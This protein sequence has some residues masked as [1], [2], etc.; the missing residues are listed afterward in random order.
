MSRGLFSSLSLPRQEC[1][2]PLM[3]Q[4][5]PRPSDIDLL[6]RDFLTA[7]DCHIHAHTACPYR[8]HSLAL[9]SPSDLT[10]Y[11]CSLCQRMTKTETEELTLILP[12][13]ISLSLKHHRILS[14]LPSGF[15]SAHLFLFISTVTSLIHGT[16]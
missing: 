4:L 1:P 9:T 3:L 2:Y 8:T 7:L 14:V 10:I 5:L 15:F 11:Q 6:P 13:S 16:T 12:S